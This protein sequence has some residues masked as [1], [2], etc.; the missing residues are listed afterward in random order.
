M[1]GKMYWYSANTLGSWLAT[2]PQS[3][4][5]QSHPWPSISSS[6]V[7]RGRPLSLVQQLGSPA[8]RILWSQITLR[9]SRHVAVGP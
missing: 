1:L 9:E 7:L 2:P 5:V 6:Q 4:V 3:D 8:M